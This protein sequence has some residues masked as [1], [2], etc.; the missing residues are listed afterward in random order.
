M[1]GVSEVAREL[2]LPKTTVQRALTTLHAARWIKPA[3]RGGRPGWELAAKVLRVARYAGA[4]DALREAALPV[5]EELHRATGETVHLLVRDGDNVVLIERIESDHPVRTVQ[6]MGSATPVHAASTGKA[7]LA[8]L[9]D[10]EREAVLA[11]PLAALTEQTVTDPG[12]LRAQLAEIRARGWA[13]NAG[14]SW[15]GLTAIGAPVLDAAG[16]P[17]AAVSIS[18]PSERLPGSDWPRVADLVVDAAA[19]ISRALG[20]REPRPLG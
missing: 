12:R 6:P 11:G 13:V 17:I 18:S 7:I 10:D 4:G 20:Y 19:R 1:A 14:E 2:Q 8:F 16:A 5:M 15:A 9:P 3:D